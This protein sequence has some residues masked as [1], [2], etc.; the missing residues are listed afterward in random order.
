MSPLPPLTPDDVTER[1]DFA[2]IRR[3]QLLA[4]HGCELQHADAHER[5][6]LIQEFFFHLLG[7]VDVLAQLVNERHSLGVIRSMSPLATCKTS[8]QV[9]RWRAISRRCTPI[10]G[11]IPFRPI[12]TATR[13]TSTGRTTIGI[14]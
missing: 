9:I 14:W 6:Q 12:R 13:A 5:Q 7:A 11:E 2:R 10:P 1:L 3:D 8:S 4:L